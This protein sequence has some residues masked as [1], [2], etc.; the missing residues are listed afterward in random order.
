[1]RT[2]LV[3]LLA[4]AVATTCACRRPIELP[5]ELEGTWTTRHE[6]YADRA[7]TLTPGQIAFDLGEHGVA[8]HAIDAVYRETTNEGED[9]ITIVYLGEEGG[10][11][12]FSLIYDEAKG[13]ALV[14]K[15]QPGI[16]WTRERS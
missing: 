7:F 12:R 13:P 3:I 4:L 5:A 2:A 6:T 10:A 15:N 8:R 11:L 9:L 1:M 14:P 16:R